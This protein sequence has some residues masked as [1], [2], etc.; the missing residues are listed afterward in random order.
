MSDEVIRFIRR[1]RPDEDHTDFP[2]IAFRS[3]VPDIAADY[4]GQ[5]V[6]EDAR[7]PSVRDLALLNN[8]DRTFSTE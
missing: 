3:A 5:A 4:I 7:P 6:C 8:E 2:V 1:P